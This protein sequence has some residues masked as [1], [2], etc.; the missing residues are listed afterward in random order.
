MIAIEWTNS[1][2]AD[3]LAWSSITTVEEQV[4]ITLNNALGS[5]GQ[6]T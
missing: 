4:S 1:K 3:E 5:I 6:Y 2:L